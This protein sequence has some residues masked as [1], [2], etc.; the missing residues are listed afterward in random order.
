[1][2]DYEASRFVM[3]PTRLINTQTLNFEIKFAHIQPTATEYPEY[4]IL[5][6]RWGPHEISYQEFLYFTTPAAARNDVVARILGIDVEKE[7]ADGFRKVKAACSMALERGHEYIWIDAC[8]INKDSSAELSEAINSMY[9]W[10]RTSG[11]CFIYLEDVTMAAN[12]PVEETYAKVLRSQWWT[13]GW[14]L[15]ELLASKNRTFFDSRW[16]AI[17]RGPELN[18]LIVK[19]SKVAAPYLFETSGL[20]AP[21]A[22][23]LTWLAGRATTRAEDMGYCMLGLCGVSMTLLYGEGRRAFDRLQRTIITERY[24]ESIFWSSSRRLL[25]RSPSDFRTFYEEFP[26]IRVPARSP[27]QSFT[28]YTVSGAGVRM[29]VRCRA[30]SLPLVVVGFLVFDSDGSGVAYLGVRVFVEVRGQFESAIMQPTSPSAGVMEEAYRTC[31]RIV[32][33]GGDPFVYRDALLSWEGVS[34]PGVQE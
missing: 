31:E 15:Q 13:R 33:E 25:A 14:T 20:N 4:A 23:R 27:I 18:A 12:E 32:G 1:M 6:H 11:E 7:H 8:C 9:T 3:A 29:R 16:H 26:P 22:E 2:V 21:T 24:D 34:V 19:K 10:Y 28:A 30:L 5:S 17:P